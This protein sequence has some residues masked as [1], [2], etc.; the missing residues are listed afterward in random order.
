VRDAYFTALAE[1]AAGDDRIWALTGDLGIGLFD[2]F[3]RVAPGRYLNV[4]I[5]EQ[6]LV[7]VAAGL[8]YAGKL[9]FAYSIAPFMT[10]RPHD[11]IRVDV[12]LPA[13]N[14][15]LVGVGGGV[16]YGTL[17][18][19]HHAIEDVA[20]MRCLPNMTVLTPADPGEAYRATLAAAAHP[21]PVYLRLGKNGE[22]RALP[23]GA[24]FAIGRALRLSVGDDVAILSAGAILPEAQRAAA[25][26]EAR[27]VRV[28][29][30]HFG[31]VKTLDRAAVA[32]AAATGSVVT[33]EEHTVIGGFGGAVA[34]AMAE[35]GCAA[36]LRRVGLRDVFA[37]EVG[38]RA[39]L[40]AQ[41]GLDARAVAA[42]AA[43]LLD[44][45]PHPLDEEA[46][47]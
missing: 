5:A 21:G 19:T 32:E 28:S 35:L 40:I 37:H 26:L 6:N 45:E 12:A 18:P 20:L 27:G 47:G 29:L 42:A 9:P 41:H 30:T 2:E 44:M 11:Q 25:L 38:S 16:A 10:S 46:A 31:T 24:E 7:G 13:A 14:V 43:D 3:E 17:G 4:G 23:A 33:V 8:A 15:K 22:P 36:R 39:H 1:L 34:E